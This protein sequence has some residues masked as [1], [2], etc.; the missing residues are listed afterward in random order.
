MDGFKSV[1]RRAGIRRARLAAARMHVERTVLART[2]RAD[3][4]A[5]SRILCYHSVGTPLWGINDVRPEQLRCHLE[6]ALEAGFHFVSPEQLARTG[7]RPHEL[8][9]T[10]DDGLASV[11]ANAA[12]I[13][14][15]YGIPWMLFVVTDWAAGRHHFG[16][17]VFMGWREIERLAAR[18]V[19]VGSHSVSHPNFADLAPDETERELAVSRRVRAQIHSPQPS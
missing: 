15:D 7:G 9:L 14:A 17:G 11:A 19:A 3:T 5:R 4:G 6:L 1:L 10:F 2:S 13:L 16:D 8:A 12:P 18:G